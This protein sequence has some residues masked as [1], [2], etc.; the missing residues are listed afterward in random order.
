MTSRTILGV[1]QITRGDLAT[2]LGLPAATVIPIQ[3]L[4]EI[5]TPESISETVEQVIERALDQ[6]PDLQ[7]EA[8]N[9]RAANAERRQARSAFYPDLKF[10]AEPTAESLYFQQQNLPWGHTA[11]LTGQAGADPELDGI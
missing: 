2:A 11:D 9:V 7:A 6:R 3:P 4:D 8:A 5:P 10:Q 1:E